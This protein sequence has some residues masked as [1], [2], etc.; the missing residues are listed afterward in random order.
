MPPVTSQ[1][2]DRIRTTSF[3]AAFALLTYLF[4][5]V[6]KPFIVPL[7]ASAILVVF[8]YPWHLR[9]ERRYGAGLASLAS[10]LL[11]TTILIVPMLLV[12]SAFVREAAAA[13]ASVQ[14]A[15]AA[16]EFERVGHWWS[17]I[18]HRAPLVAGITLAD[19][20]ADLGRRLGGFAAESAGDL[21]RNV[22][23]VLFDL[24]VMIFA[25]FFL[26]RDARSIM[27]LVRRVLPFE[28]EQREQVISQAHDLIR[29][30][31]VSA[32]AV[33]SAQ[34][35]AGGLLFWAVGIGA[36]VFWGVTMAFL[37]LLPIGA[38][39]I[40]LPA[41]IWLLVNGSTARGVIL[42]AVGTGVVSAIDNVL[43]P[44]L[45]S[46]RAQMN[47]LLVLISLLGG[48]AAFGLIGLVI[49]PVVVATMTSLLSAYTGPPAERAVAQ[50]R[51]GTL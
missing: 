51:V 30:S 15:V 44:A 34:G 50:E 40:W 47:G 14:E 26:F 21:L 43:R 45:L 49:G 48:I 41:G 17:W 46:G 33:A 16:G 9:L 37:S 18:Q 20:A 42:L 36:P 24:I 4:Y 1:N 23:V 12:V 8:F 35:A 29:A 11:V 38:W 27:R 28:E 6:A 22:G 5:I 39:A 2:R 13:A 32:I 7:C 3:Y 25:M 31:V 19:V 10:T